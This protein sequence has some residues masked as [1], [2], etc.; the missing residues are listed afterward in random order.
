VRQIVVF[1]RSTGSRLHTPPDL[2][3]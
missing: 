1:R 2:T 3:M